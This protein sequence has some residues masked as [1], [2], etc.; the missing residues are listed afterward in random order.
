MAAPAPDAN[1]RRN[2]LI[3]E[4]R[5]DAAILAIVAVALWGVMCGL[6][7]LLTH[8]LHATAIERWDGSVNPWFVARRSPRWNTVT[9][10]LTYAGETATVIALGLIVFVVVRLSLH[11]WRESVF[12]AVALVGE[13]TIFVCTTLVIERH[14]PG[15]PHLDLAPPTSSFPSGHTAAAITLF[16][17][18]AILAVRMTTRRWPRIL[19][20]SCAIL[21]PLS[22]ALARIYRGMHFPTDV[23][24]SVILALVWLSVTSAVILRDRGALD[25][26]TQAESDSRV[27]GGQRDQ[28]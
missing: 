20:V 21:L 18:L 28:P 13:V 10:W 27:P 16:G 24:G 8:S 2:R 5:T 11:R 12:L 23:L 14:R 19:A 26:D 25:R 15:V 4:I 3:A 17:A 6:G 7:L 22:V 9:H 1:D